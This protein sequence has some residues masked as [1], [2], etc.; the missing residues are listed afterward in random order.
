MGT[1]SAMRGMRLATECDFRRPYMA[2]ANLL[3]P[4][5]D[6]DRLN[7]WDGNGNVVFPKVNCPGYHSEGGQRV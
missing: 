5:S 2:E 4:F 6:E 7:L 3:P 1:S